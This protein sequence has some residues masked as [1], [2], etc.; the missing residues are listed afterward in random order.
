METYQ[1]IIISAAAWT[2]ASV[3]ILRVIISI[4]EKYR[5]KRKEVILPVKI[6][7]KSTDRPY[8]LLWN[9]SGCSELDESCALYAAKI[10]GIHEGS[11]YLE[12]L[13]RDRIFDFIRKGRDMY[14]NPDNSYFKLYEEIQHS[15]LIKSER[16]ASRPNDCKQ[17]ILNAIRRG[18]EY[19][20]IYESLLNNITTKS[21]E[22]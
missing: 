7:F 14:K 21:K 12:R 16:G 17:A 22:V 4:K 5:F 2:I 18:E 8:G 20:Q 11:E 6:D 1:I 19:K 9:L 13:Y 10:S 3:I 15:P